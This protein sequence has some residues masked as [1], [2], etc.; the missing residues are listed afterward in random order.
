MQPMQALHSYLSSSCCCGHHLRPGLE[1]QEPIPGTKTHHELGQNGTSRARNI[2]SGCMG[3]KLQHGGISVDATCQWLKQATSEAATILRAS[4]RRLK[5]S[6]VIY[7]HP[8]TD[9]VTPTLMHTMCPFKQRQR[10]Q[11]TLRR[12]Q[13]KASTHLQQAHHVPP[14]NHPAP[15]APGAGWCM[16]PQIHARVQP[17]Q[18]QAHHKYQPLS[19][20][21]A[22]QAGKRESHRVEQLCLSKALEFLLSAQGPAQQGGSRSLLRFPLS[23]PAQR[24]C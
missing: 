1:G 24:F 8:T 17:S 11:R 7:H 5:T 12:K 20:G 6:C 16:T 3:M 10:R 18:A 9:P 4:A 2:P 21:P 22:Q 19:V 15:P 13:S 14:S 23:L